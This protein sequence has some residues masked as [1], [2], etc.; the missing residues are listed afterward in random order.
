MQ[1]C[2]VHVCV[3]KVHNLSLLHA[4]RIYNVFAR[5]V[6][7]TELHL[8]RRGITHL[9]DEMEAFESLEVRPTKQISILDAVQRRL[10]YLV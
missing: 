6:F 4:N 3:H 1:P 8:A 9:T 2:G 7:A 10:R 5:D